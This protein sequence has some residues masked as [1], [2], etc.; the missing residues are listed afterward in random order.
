M[1][2]AGWDDY[3][4]TF[5]QIDAGNGVPP[6]LARILAGRKGRLLDLGCGEGQ[7][8]EAIRANYPDWDLSGFEVSEVRAEV[9]RRRGF[10]VS[11]DTQ[12]VVQFPAGSFHVVASTHVIEH[13]PDDHE[14]AAQLRRMVS[15]EGFVYL[16]TPV[17]LRG[18]WYFRRNPQAG[19]VLDPTHVREYRSAA[20][21]DAVLDKA[22]L[23]VEDEELTPISYPLASAF[24]VVRRLLRLA[25][26]T[27]RPRGLAAKRIRIPRYRQQ[28]VIARPV[29]GR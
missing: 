12:G 5:P 21:V 28:A 29:A 4:E 23:R 2:S 19:W 10:D 25:Q 24:M 15:S 17:R 3:A 7:L 11:V 6:L 1:T 9:A 18:A 8:L 13:V 22:G 26:S 27:A 14:Y 20:E 16:E